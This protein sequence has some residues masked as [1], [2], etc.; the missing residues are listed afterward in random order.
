MDE[1]GGPNHVGFFCFAPIIADKRKGELHYTNIFYFLGHFS[2]FVK[3]DA[4]RIISSSNR[5][6]L[7]TTAFINPDD[8]IVVIV[9]NTTDKEMNYILWLNGKA[10]EVK[11]F[12]NSIT[13]LVL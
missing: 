12:P 3:P 1:T 4:K 5:D 13:T 11:S 9:L 6:I 8:T 2:K 10:A 7:Q